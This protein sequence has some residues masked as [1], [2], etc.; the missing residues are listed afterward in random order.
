M[1]E[2]LCGRGVGGGDKTKERPTS[3]HIEDIG[4]QLSIFKT[5]LE[6]RRL[7]IKIRKEL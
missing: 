3:D 4:Q 2:K 6:K 7:G 1:N 5:N